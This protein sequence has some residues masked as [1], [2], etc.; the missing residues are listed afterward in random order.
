MQARVGRVLVVDDDALNRRLLTSSL[1]REGH[2]TTAVEDGGS[3]LA[4]LAGSPFDLVLLD[5][6]MP[7]LDGIEVLERLKQDP[8]L[9]HIPVIMISGVEDTESI[10]RCIEAGAEDFLPKP[11]DPVILRARVNAGL[12]RKALHDLERER[13]RQVFTRFLPESLVDQVLAKSDGEP[14]IGAE[15]LTGTVL[16]ADLRGFT[17]YAEARPVD[18]VIEALNRYVSLMTDAILDNGGTMIAC[19]GDGVIAAFGAP[20]PQDDHADRALAAARVM[21]GDKLREFNAWLKEASLGDGFRMGVGINSG[22]LMSGSV[23]S[24]R[25]LDYTVIGDTVN[26][27]SRIEGLT[28]EV[29]FPVLLSDETYASLSGEPPEDLTFVDEFEIR[30]RRSRIKLW[31]LA[32]PNEQGPGR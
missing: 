21:A 22:P 16:F 18:E 19:L 5:I 27:A 11:F 9:L 14:T 13:V 7:G 4:A 1:E 20:V 24:S 30:G 10:A 31:G 2:S 6:L 17:T 15:L 26:A 23:G 3:A 25:R 32:A 29:A 12:N 8:A 28:K